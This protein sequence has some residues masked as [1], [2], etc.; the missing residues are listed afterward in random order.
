MFASTISCCV[1]SSPFR[2][3]RLPPPLPPPPP[4]PPPKPVFE[5]QG[6]LSLRDLVIPGLL[7]LQGMLG[8]TPENV[9]LAEQASALL[10]RHDQ[11]VHHLL[12]FKDCSLDALDAMSAVLGILAH[13]SKQPFQVKWPMI[14][15]GST[16]PSLLCSGLVYSTD[17][18]CFLRHTYGPRSAAVMRSTVSGFSCSLQAGYAVLYFGTLSPYIYIYMYQ[19]IYAPDIDCWRDIRRTYVMNLNYVTRTR[20]LG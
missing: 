11:L 10:A 1:P 7:L 6:K 17:R 5:S 19:V 2:C 4:P 18:G 13:V 12:L 9:L 16:C 8:S 20:L 15:L 14:W 3:V